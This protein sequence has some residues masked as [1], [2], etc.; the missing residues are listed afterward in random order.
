[1][2]EAL[3]VTLRVA[4]VLESLGVP[5]L[6]GGS[7]ASS[8]FGEP[9]ATYDADVV[10]DLR[11][12]HVDPFI[13]ALRDEFYLDEPAIRDAVGGRSTFNLIH[14]ETMFKVDVF[15]ARNDAPTAQELERRRP[16]ALPQM[17]GAE[18]VMASPEDVVV[19]KLYWYRLGDHISER[20]WSDARGV[21][22]VSGRKLD[23]DYMEK[24]AEQMGVADLL[25]RALGEAGLR[26]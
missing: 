15:V 23:L 14:L 1:M 16:Y 26:P 17:S 22:K 19:Q 20:Q 25:L 2:E 18:I 12:E 10:A 21:L 5:Y 3:G 8:F 9:R 7:L 11:A 24:L 4:R 13:T 6:V